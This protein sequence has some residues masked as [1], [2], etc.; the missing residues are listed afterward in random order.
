MSEIFLYEDNLTYNSEGNNDPK[1]IFYSRKLHHPSMNSGPTIGRGYDLSQKTVEQV[2]KELQAAS[3]SPNKIELLIKG[4]GLIG[5]EAKKFIT[6]NKNF[7]ISLEEQQNLFSL[8]YP[9][10]QKETAKLFKENWDKI[11]ATYQEILVDLR[12]RGDITKSRKPF[13]D[14]AIQKL[15]KGENEDFDNFIK[16]DSWKTHCNKDRIERRVKKLETYKKNDLSAVSTKSGS[17]TPDIS[18]EL[19]KGGIDLNIDW[20]NAKINWKEE[21]FLGIIFDQKSS[22]LLL[23][24]RNEKKQ[25]LVHLNSENMVNLEDLAVVLKIFFDPTI[26]HKMISFS[27]DP[28]EKNNPQGPFMKKVFY[29][30]QLENR[31]ILAG[32]KFGEDI[33]NADL[34]MKQMS[35]GIQHDNKTKFNYPEELSK[36][37][38]KPQHEMRYD[39]EFSQEMKWS[40]AWIVV[41]NIKTYKTRD[42]L[43]LIEE[44]KMGVEARQLNQKSDGSLKDSE[45]QDKDDECYKFSKKLAEVYDITGKYY[46][47]FQRMRE[48]TTAI[49][50]GK[51]I[52][53]NNIS[54]DLELINLIYKQNLIENYQEKVPSINYKEI[55]EI[56]ENIPIDMK[57]IAKRSLVHSSLEI[58]PE[59]ID[60]AIKQIQEKNGGKIFYDTRIKKKQ[61]FLFGGVDLTSNILTN[62]NE[63]NFLEE[64]KN[65]EILSQSTNDESFS[66][67]FKGNNLGK[68]IVKQKNKIKVDLTE[69]NLKTFPFLSKEKCAVCENSLNLSELKANHICR[70]LIG[71]YNY[72]IHHHPFK[73]KTC[74]KIAMGN[75]FSINNKNYHL[76]CVVCS[77]CKKKIEEPTIAC[78]EDKLFH[79]VCYETYLKNKYSMLGK[80][81][82]QEIREENLNLN[83]SEKRKSE[84][85]RELEKKINQIKLKELEKTRDCRGKTVNDQ[86]NNIIKKVFRK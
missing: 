29:P 50:M 6:E 61:L 52:Y 85:S 3:F 76:E 14:L 66:N 13:I 58:T 36:Y 71:K 75:Y 19:P 46:K 73:C 11:P 45:I 79:K 38:L 24:K 4:V 28:D 12:Y 69:F 9:I 1:S 54:V 56:K 33:F 63:K 47:S 70:K 5:N 62:K 82:K 74:N 53:E 64:D 77:V 20:N 17:N 8:I 67:E 78:E 22:E 26:K 65:E 60:L 51:W 10:Y 44:I 83:F 15:V 2:R 27:L 25:N 59:N 48:I 23:I 57:E 41:N 84:E 18:F 72:C 80:L 30:D 34:I 7:E 68:Y 16:D 21:K 55:T 32:T 49:V 31:K 86:Q 81:G 35:L 37:G 40:R 39:R 42:E 43:L